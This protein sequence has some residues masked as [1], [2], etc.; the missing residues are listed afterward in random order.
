[1]AD[2]HDMHWKHKPWSHAH[3]QSETLKWWTKQL[4]VL[5][6]QLV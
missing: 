2:K 6:K 1:M 4:V 3:R 5:S